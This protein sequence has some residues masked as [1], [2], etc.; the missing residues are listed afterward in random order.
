M[1]LWVKYSCEK[2]GVFL[3]NTKIREANLEQAK[4]RTKNDL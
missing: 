4:F 1:N 3:K 2:F